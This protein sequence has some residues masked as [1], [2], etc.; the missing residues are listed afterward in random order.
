ME[1]NEAFQDIA[2]IAGLSPRVTEQVRE[3]C[4]WAVGG[5]RSSVA[6]FAV[7]SGVKSIKV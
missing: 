1:K 6:R 7:L 3:G 4:R 5:T 2:G